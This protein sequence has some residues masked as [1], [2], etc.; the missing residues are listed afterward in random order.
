MAA[1]LENMR[2]RAS[3]FSVFRRGFQLSLAVLVAMSLSGCQDRHE[4]HQKLTV[5]VDTPSGEVSGSS[6]EVNGS[7]GQDYNYRYLSWMDGSSLKIPSS[8]LG[9]SLD[10]QRETCH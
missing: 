6:H 10:R 9:R 1:L 7:C 8:Q 4:W 5:V 2:V 3:G